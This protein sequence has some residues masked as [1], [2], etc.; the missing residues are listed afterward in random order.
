MHCD[1]KLGRQSQG[2]AICLYRTGCG[3]VYPVKCSA[4]LTGASSVLRSKRAIEVIVAI[5]RA[6]VKLRDPAQFEWRK[7]T[8]VAHYWLEVTALSA[9]N[10]QAGMT[11]P[12][13]IKEEPAI[14]GDKT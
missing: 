6:F 12:M 5:M 7:V 14:Y 3:N 11:K 10:A 1:F 4:Y 9:C 13:Q 8:K 2:K